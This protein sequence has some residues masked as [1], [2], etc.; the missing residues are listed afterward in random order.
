M[1]HALETR[2]KNFALRYPARVNIGIL[3]LRVLPVVMVLHGISK[4][5]GFSG[6]AAGLESR[7]V[8]SIAPTFFA[9]LIVAGELFL[10]IFIALGFFTRIAAFFESL[11]M[12]GIW[13]F[14]DVYGAVSTGSGFITEHGGIL[15]ESAL[16]Y[17]F[18]ALPLVFLGAG[19]YSLDAALAKK[20]N[21]FFLS[22]I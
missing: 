7:P 10:P 20:G 1:T 17:L 3:L 22:Q 13:I 2:E 12:L 14:V 6:F 21:K 4:L 8:A 5:S 11:M 16:M 15:G 18:L 19:R 9:L